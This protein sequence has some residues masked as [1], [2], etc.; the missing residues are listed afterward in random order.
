MV[1]QEEN[2]QTDDRSIKNFDL[3]EVTISCLLENT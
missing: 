1:T 3:Q 2:F